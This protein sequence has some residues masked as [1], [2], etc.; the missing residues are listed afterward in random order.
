MIAAFSSFVEF[1]AAIY[2]TMAVNNDYCANFWT[3]RYY[4]EMQRLLDQYDFK[5]SSTMFQR[6]NA[7][8]KE[9]YEKV[10]GKAH[11]RGSLLLM[12][13][14]TYLIYMGFEKEDTT[15]S[16]YAPLL[17][18]NIF[19]DI[20]LLFPSILRSWRH[21]TIVTILNL[22]LL[23]FSYTSSCSSL[24]DSVA[25]G[26]MCKYLPLFLIPTVLLPILYQLYIYWLYS[27][28]YKGYLK[29]NVKEEYQRYKTSLN[30]IENKR[31]DEVDPIYLNKLTESFF[32]PS[33]D[34]TATDFNS[35]LSKQ[36]LQVASPSTSKLFFSWVRIHLSKIK[37]RFS[38]KQKMNE[39]VETSPANSPLKQYI[40]SST[41]LDF[42]VQFKQFQSWKKKSK[43]NKSLKVFCQ[44]HSIA[45]KDM[46]AW[47]RVN[48][49]R[50]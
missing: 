31:Q 27:R 30:G 43:T 18:S 20:I 8:I 15:L 10:Q 44:Q 41:P 11:F 12:L 32:N 6:L 5:G 23:F 1:F 46:T 19:I 40:T 21:V 9:Q 14:V 13:C 2:V 39:Q 3:P 42:S 38:S 33:G 37:K 49:P 47:L 48:K 22:F 35:V 28:V 24:N 34:A 7:T 4:K 16:F 36:L 45:Y 25:I 26:F 17:Y 50:T 29:H